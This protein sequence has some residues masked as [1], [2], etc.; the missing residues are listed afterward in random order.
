MGLQVDQVATGRLLTETRMFG[1][2]AQKEFLI[3]VEERAKLNRR[4]Q[5][6]FDHIRGQMSHMSTMLNEN[7]NRVSM[8]ANHLKTTNGLVRP[9]RS[10]VEELGNSTHVLQLQQRDTSTH[11][12]YLQALPT[13]QTPR[14][15]RGS[16]R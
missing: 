13:L 3:H 2:R 6:T 11:I 16:L 10:R 4:D 9:L 8:H 7:I 14:R 1:E 12:E 5:E 15:G